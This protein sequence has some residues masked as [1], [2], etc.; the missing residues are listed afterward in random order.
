MSSNDLGRASVDMTQGLSQRAAGRPEDLVNIVI[1]SG[2]FRR[3]ELA[4]W[5]AEL[6]EPSP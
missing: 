4:I 2:Q 1:I 6:V 5:P 3:P